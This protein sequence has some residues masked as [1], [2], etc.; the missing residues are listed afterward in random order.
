MRSEILQL[1]ALNQVDQI[2]PLI[3]SAQERTV[4]AQIVAD[5]RNLGDRYNI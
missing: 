1:V 2:E 3:A 4:V 5:R